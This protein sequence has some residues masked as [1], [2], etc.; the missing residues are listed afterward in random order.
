VFTVALLELIYGVDL[1]DEELNPDSI[2]RQL[3]EKLRKQPKMTDQ[4]F[5]AKLKETKDVI[6]KA[7]FMTGLEEMGA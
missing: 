6:E 2:P 3:A 4:E 5:V 7:S 1:P